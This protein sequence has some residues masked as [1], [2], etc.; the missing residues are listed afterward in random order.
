MLVYVTTGL[1][2][3]QTYLVITL[4]QAKSS[5][6][7]ILQVPLVALLQQNW[8]MCS[9]KTQSGISCHAVFTLQLPQYVHSAAEAQPT[10]FGSQIF[11]MFPGL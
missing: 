2:Y 1:K 4:N 5:F 10:Q 9:F 7:I 8:Q 6:T 11:L 3:D